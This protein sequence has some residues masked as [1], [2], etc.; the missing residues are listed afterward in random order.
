[1]PKLGKSALWG[2]SIA[3][4]WTWGL[5]LF[6]SVQ[7]ALH[8]GLFGLLLFAIPNAIGLMLFGLLTHRI[9]K[10]YERT[11]DMENHFFTTSNSMRYV[12]LAYQ[13]VAI[14]LTFFAI[15]RYLFMPLGIDLILVVLIMLGAALMLGEQFDIARI[16]WSH[17]AMFAVIALCAGGLATGVG[18]WMNSNDVPWQLAAGERSVGS[19]YFLGYFVPILCGFLIGPWL[20]VQQWHRAIQI[21]REQGSIRGAY[22][23]G[24][25]LFFSILIFHGLLALTVRSIGG[26]GLILPAPDGLFHAKDYIV[27]FFWS[28]GYGFGPIVKGFYIAFLCLCVLSTLDS[29]YV[30][31]KWYLGRLVRKSEHIILSII[32]AQVISSPVLVCLIAVAIAAVSVPMHVELEY[33]MSFYGAFSV[34]Y[35]LV[36]LFRTTFAPKFTEF[37]QTTLFSVAAFSLGIFGIGFFKEWWFLMALGAVAPMVHG[38]VTISG[39]AVVDDLQKALPRQD[40]AEEEAAADSISG[41]AMATS[42][43]AL[44]TA[45]KRLDPAAAERF[46]TVIQRVEPQAAQALATVLQAVQPHQTTE[47]ALTPSKPIDTD[48]AIEHAQGHYEG[49]WFVHTFMSTYSDTNSVGN[50]YF[51][52]YVI[53]VGKVREMFFR[54]CM[55]GFDLQSTNFFILTRAFEHKFNME[56]REFEIITVKIRVADFNRKFATLE[57]QIF[58]QAQQLLGKGKQVLLFVSSKDYQIVDLPDQVKRAFLPHL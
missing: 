9:G 45:I 23:I 53:W 11:R 38:F 17:L 8:F 16:K 37:A 14:T 2:V 6:F 20:D 7:M 58:N 4:S 54:D 48:A 47:G 46:H 13:L 27:R 18:S 35:A 33:F 15:F 26:P 42:V 41:K 5:G 51:G 36:F 34:G 3:L 12:I 1:M 25:S 55:P 31:L 44:Q 39:R 57:H 32:P 29:G 21:H 43:Q 19:W 52:Q 30:S 49:K 24:G 22:V 40:T 10:R 28:P 56:A 50:V